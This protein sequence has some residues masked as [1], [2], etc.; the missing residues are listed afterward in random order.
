MSH[1]ES[2]NVLGMPIR[3]ARDHASTARTVAEAVTRTAEVLRS[4]WDLPVPARC[5]LDI[6][7]DLAALV[8]KTAPAGYRALLRLTRPLWW[9]RVN[10]I[11]NA[12]GGLT[13]PW[14]NQP[15]V[16][17]KPAEVIASAPEGLGSRL[18]L[19]ET[20]PL[21]K[22]RHIASHEFTHACTAHLRLPVWLNEGLAMRAVDHV[23]ERETVLDSTQALARDL[24]SLDAAALR[25]LKT[26]DTDEVVALYATGY[27][28]VRRVDE[29]S[30]QEIVTLLSRPR[31]RRSVSIEAL[32]LFG[33]GLEG[34]GAT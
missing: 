8:L 25:R 4:R 24:R 19:S 34:S 18:Y 33:Q 10:R 12:S 28:A 23:A 15:A 14:R 32:R 13:L 9:R 2:I 30:P 17:V 26:S 6:S 20:D 31:S 29:Q 21:E 22:V 1:T 7:A 3:F 27:W 5:T 11:A 16:G